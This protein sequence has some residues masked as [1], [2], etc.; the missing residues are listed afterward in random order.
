M[1]ADLFVALKVLDEDHLAAGFAVGPQ[2]VRHVALK[3]ATQL[4]SD[5]FGQP[6]HVSRYSPS[7]VVE[8]GS[9]MGARLGLGIGARF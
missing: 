6:A 5:V 4:G 7:A 3:Q 2:V 1:R 9:N 8:E